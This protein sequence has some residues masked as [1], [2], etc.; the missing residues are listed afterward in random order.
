MRPGPA[1]STP[2]WFY[3]AG[4]WSRAPKHLDARANLAR[5]TGEAGD[6]VAARDQ[7]AALLPVTERVLGPE[8]PDTLTIRSELARW[9]ANA[10]NAQGAYDQLARLLPIAER[11]LGPEHRE[12]LTTNVRLAYLTGARDELAAVLLPETARVMG[13]EH[14]DTLTARRY[15]AQLNGDEESGSRPRP[16]RGLLPVTERVLGPS[17]ATLWLS[18]PTSP[19]GP[20]GPA[21]VPGLESVLSGLA[22]VCSPAPGPQVSPADLRRIT[23]GARALRP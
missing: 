11:V 9:T 10:G 23:G 14:R 2:V 12:T 4:L 16:A 20:I 18:A 19:T 6:P 8:H 17:T 22:P 7:L 13:R 1:T 5:W 3:G 21:V 15:L